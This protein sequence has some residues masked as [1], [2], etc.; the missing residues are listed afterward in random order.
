M[1]NVPMK[2]LCA[3]LFML[4]SS[5]FV[6][7]SDWDDHY[8]SLASE[9]TSDLTLWQTLQQHPELSDFREVLSKT[10]VFKYHR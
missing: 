3:T 6:S 7:C 4:C 1:A 10:K 8:E 5:F 2:L 9:G